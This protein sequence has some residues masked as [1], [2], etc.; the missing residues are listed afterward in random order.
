M[1]KNKALS[2][3]IIFWLF[4]IVFLWLAVTRLDQTK[5]VLEILST[6][7]WYWIAP[8][9]IC[10]LFFY[11]L[12]AHFISHVFRIFRLN[13]SWRQ[14]LPVYIAS[15]F[16]DV[17]LPISTFGK[18]AV[19]LRHSKRQNLSALNTGIGVSFVMLI[20]VS[21]FIIVALVSLLTLLIFGQ[22]RA[23]LYVTLLILI[24]AVALV[25]LYLISLAVYKRP[26]S[27]L[28]LWLIKQIA[29]PAGY[30]N[31]Q[32]SEIEG[33]FRE[34]GT[35]VDKKQK[36][37]RTGLCLAIS[38]HLINMLTLAFVFLAF[39][40]HLNILALLAA[41]TAGLLYTV[42]SITPQGVGVVETIMVATIHSF[43]F[44]IPTAAVVTLVFRSI[45]YWL[46]VF[47]GFYFFSK[48]EFESK[49]AKSTQGD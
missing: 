29:R 32:P 13:Q 21:A 17:A 42:V 10:Q 3:K 20:E 39:T 6:G 1:T 15:K 8:A 35:D 37:I 26:P 4:L 41:Y 18:V 9:L 11:P 23:Y 45:L 49:Q 46:P 40:G 43:G 30:K 36:Q 25:I 28:V 12:Y 22:S 47:A 33:V 38:A 2:K 34:I 48:L 31:V 24:L 19:F 44:D 16:T 14:I 7:R 5:N 27:R